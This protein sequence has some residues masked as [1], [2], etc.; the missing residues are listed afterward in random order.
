MI[1]RKALCGWELNLRNWRWEWGGR[2]GLGGPTYI[3]TGW[4]G[5]SGLMTLVG[6]AFGGS[7]E[8]WS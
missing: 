6:R 8:T 1:G 4:A 3:F 7:W 5:E 2:E